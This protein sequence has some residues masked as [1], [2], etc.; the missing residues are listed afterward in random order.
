MRAWAEGKHP[1]WAAYAIQ[2]ASSAE[3]SYEALGLARSGGFITGDAGPPPL[4]EWLALYRNHRAFD[5]VLAAP[6][7]T[8]EDGELPEWLQ[9]DVNVDSLTA[10]DLR[11]AVVFAQKMLEQTIDGVLS[12]DVT[13]PASIG[14]A[15]HSTE[16]RFFFCVAFP[17]W[18]EYGQPPVK[19]QRKAR[20]GD[21]Y[22]LE[23]LLRLDKFILEDARV[24]RVF[25]RVMASKGKALK[26]RLSKALAGVPLRKLTRNKVKVTLAALVYKTLR[27]AD[28][29]FREL[30]KRFPHIEKPRPALDLPELRRLFDAVAQDVHGELQDNDLPLGDEAFR[31]AVQRELPFWPDLPAVGQK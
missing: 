24:R 28:A 21:T 27:E 14:A 10:E 3:A 2:V 4:G 12:E 6:L 5:T 25:H 13:N 20:R 19:L 11:K 9:V 29:R 16:G 22:A 31:K 8:G 23:K 30:D 18:L 1:F 17:C 7:M 26:E 15:L